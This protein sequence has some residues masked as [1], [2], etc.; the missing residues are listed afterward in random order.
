[1]PAAIG[2][3]PESFRTRSGWLRA[4]LLHFFAIGGALFALQAV[5][6]GAAPV[7]QEPIVVTAQQLAQLEALARRELGRD[8]TSAELDGR[9]NAWVDEELLLREARA[10]RWHR[11]D[12]VVHMRLAQN[13]RFL[14]A[15]PDADDLT[16]AELAERAFEVGMDRTD[17]VVRRRLAERMRLAIS[18]AALDREP[19]DEELARIL[20]D[21]PE[22]YQRP[23]L[24]QL[25][26]VFLSRD[27]R[28]EGLAAAAAALRAE[29]IAAG[30]PPEEATDRAD[31][32]LVPARLPLS[33]ERSLASRLGP[34]FAE[35][36]LRAPAGHWVGPIESAYG[37]HVVWVHRYIP[38]RD[39]SIDEAR[40]ELRASW[41]AER[42]RA[43]LRDALATLREGVQVSLPAAP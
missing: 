25:T 31:P 33:S 26:Q 4:P 9:I 37:Q 36:A 14:L 13:Q 18:A 3:D 5:F 40:R 27:R 21:D 6:S 7:G 24:V 42:E 30:T 43:A 1:M 19:A 29:F 34:G 8:P 16:D 17:L 35:A 11:T 38:A 39:P 15:G 28:G 20:A 41:R 32:S 12:P 10:L 22:R 23:A 2:G